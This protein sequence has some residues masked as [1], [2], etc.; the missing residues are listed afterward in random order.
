MSDNNEAI[1]NLKYSLSKPRFAASYHACGTHITF[2]KLQN[3][4]LVAISDG[5]SRHRCRRDRY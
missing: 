4:K 3:G 2:K 5:N 1:L